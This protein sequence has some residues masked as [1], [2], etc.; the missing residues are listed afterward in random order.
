MLHGRAI[1]FGAVSPETTKYRL[2]VKHRCDSS[3]A[4]SI[5]DSFNTHLIQAQSADSEVIRWISHGHIT[6]RLLW[7]AYAR[8]MFE[9]TK[10]E[11]A[12]K[13]VNGFNSMRFYACVDS[14]IQRVFAEKSDSPLVVLQLLGFQPTSVNDGY[15]SS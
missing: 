8:I 6:Y 11:E 4:A 7:T 3:R 15:E 12:A 13:D 14:W 5:T 10:N 1:A 2:T 9:V